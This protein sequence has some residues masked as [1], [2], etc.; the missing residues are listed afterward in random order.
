ML[1]EKRL[2]VRLL[3]GSEYR[4]GFEA[5]WHGPMVDMAFAEVGGGPQFG[6]GELVEIESEDCLYLGVVQ[7][8]GPDGVS[9][10]VEHSLERRQLG[11]IQQVW[12]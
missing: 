5:A 3:N 10:L 6:I 12:G 1:Q 7:D 2:R 11:W 8:L 9:V 4:E